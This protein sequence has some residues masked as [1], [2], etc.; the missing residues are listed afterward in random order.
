MS[1]TA[2]TESRIQPNRDTRWWWDALASD[3]LLVPECRTCGMRFFPP[4][5]FCNNCGSKDVYGATTS[6]VGKVY[7]WVV[8]HRPFS[9][10][11]VDEVPYAIVAVD[12]DDGGRLI[13]RYRG[14]LTAL[15]DA[16][17]VRALA[18]DDHGD[19]VLGFATI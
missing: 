14:D 3:V 1:E 11:R 7:S 18:Y 10:E 8:I 19:K 2:V 9:P 6:A 4:Q 12:L 13:G 17:P 16:L 5:S 15:R